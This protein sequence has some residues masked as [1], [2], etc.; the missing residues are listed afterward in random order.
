M[1]LGLDYHDEKL[2]IV[3]L[4]SCVYAAMK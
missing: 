3:I 2:F 4:C 1:D